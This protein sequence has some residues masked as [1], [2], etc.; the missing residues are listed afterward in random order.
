M[1]LIFKGILLLYRWDQSSQSLIL[2]TRNP[3]RLA[4]STHMEIVR[5]ISL[6][7]SLTDIC[8]TILILDFLNKT[9]LFSRPMAR[10]LPGSSMTHQLISGRLPK[11]QLLGL[12]PIG[13]SVCVF[14]QSNTNSLVKS[15]Q[16]KAVW[17]MN[18]LKLYN[19]SQ[20]NKVRGHAMILGVLDYICIRLPLRRKRLA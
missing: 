20:L 15:N 5:A 9:R 11:R 4:S 8:G 7:I 13:G 18:W 2:R 6:T 19:P 17:G 3:I 16:A 12:Q 10:R 14:T 1:S